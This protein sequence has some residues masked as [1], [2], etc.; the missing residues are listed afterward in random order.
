MA[1]LFI[2]LI[3]S[4]HL[5]LTNVVLLGMEMQEDTAFDQVK[6]AIVLLGL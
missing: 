6:A 4:R 2:I 5:V 1:S 3:S